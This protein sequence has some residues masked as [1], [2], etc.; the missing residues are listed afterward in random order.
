MLM[1]SLEITQTL[2]NVCLKYFHYYKHA[3]HFTSFYPKKMHISSFT[4]FFVTFQSS[5]Q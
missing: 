5:I 4:Y 2:E 3:I 1:L